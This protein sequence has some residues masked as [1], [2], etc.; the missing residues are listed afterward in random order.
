MTYGTSKFRK[1]VLLIA[2]APLTLTRW[3]R[4]GRRGW[5]T[6]N[7]DRLHNLR[8][9]AVRVEQVGLAF[10]IHSG[11]GLDSARVLLA[12]RLGLK[13]RDRRRNI[14][15]FETKMMGRRPSEGEPERS[16][17]A[18]RDIL[19]DRHR[20]ECR[21]RGSRVWNT[22]THLVEYGQSVH[23]EFQP[24]PLLDPP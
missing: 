14:V 18:S 4:G 20:T 10:A 19:L 17:E 13:K 1:L 21:T 8:A 6:V 23:S 15:H 12:V 7:R 11:L 9:C 22:E 5:L 3:R 16:L 2:L 24:Q